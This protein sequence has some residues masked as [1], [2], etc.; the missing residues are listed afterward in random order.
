MSNAQCGFDASEEG[1]P[2]TLL[3]RHGPT[4]KVDI[5][6]DAGYDLKAP[7]TLARLPT[8][9]S[10]LI[11]TG[12]SVCCIDSGLARE[13]GLPVID[14]T[15]L[16]GVGGLK[17]FDKHLAQIRSLDL[18]FTYYG[19]FA[20]IELASGWSAHRVLIGRDFLSHFQ[21]TYDGPTG[22]VD[23]TDPTAPLPIYPWDGE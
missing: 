13:L 4:L 6:F 8:Q 7:R 5:G 16:A 17:T 14:Q 20:G 2:R 3:V 19:A 21:M 23:L 10:A 1:D 12:A 9:V 18:K 15:E 11:D 22:A